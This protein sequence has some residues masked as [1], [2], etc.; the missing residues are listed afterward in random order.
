MNGKSIRSYEGI[1]VKDIILGGQDG[2]VE[3]I[4]LIL[5]VG[6]ATGSSKIILI[7]GLSTAFVEAFSMGAVAYTSSKAF[8]EYVKGP[9]GKKSRLKGS[10]IAPFF[11]SILVFVANLLGSIIPLIPFFYFNLEIAIKMAL[12][13]GLLLLF[14]TGAVGGKISRI[15]HWVRSGLRVLF[16]GAVAAV[17]GYLAGLWLKSYFIV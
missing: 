7:A 15:E 9:K 1:A 2:L 10:F 14:F 17:L 4:G 8:E 6:T 13:I 16:M 3:V 5:G 11:D 12:S